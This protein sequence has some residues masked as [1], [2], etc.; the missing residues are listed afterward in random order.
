MNGDGNEHR[1]RWAR[2]RFAVIGPLLARPPGEGRLKEELRRLAEKSWRHPI[3]D[4]PVRFGRSTLERWYY[5]ARAAQSDPIGALLRRTRRDAGAHPSLSE[6]FRQA[7][8]KQYRAHRSW[9]VQLHLDNLAVEVA[10]KPALGPLP[11]YSSVLRYMRA[12][13][14][15]RQRRVHT[16]HTEGAL[17]AMRRREELEIRSFEATHVHA[18]WH[19]DFHHCSRR[20]L[21]ARA[22]SV[23]P[24]LLGILDD[25]S[26]LC[27]HAQWYLEEST[28]TLVHGLIQAIQKRRLPRALMSDNGAPMRGAEFLE[29]LAELGIAHEPTL[30]Y[31]PYQNGKQEVF[32]AQ[33]EGR[34]MAMLETVEELTLE[35]LNEATLAWVEQEYHRTP[36]SELDGQTP[37]ERYLGAPNVGRDSGEGRTLT[38]RFRLRERRRQ[39]K[40]DGTI[41]IEGGRFEIPSA[42]RHLPALTVRY[43]RWDLAV[44]HLYDERHRKT[45]VRIFPLD[46]QK[47]A[48][49][50]RR[51]LDS[52][53]APSNADP[54]PPPGEMAPLLRRLIREYR[55]SGLAP[56]YVPHSHLKT[57]PKS[58]TKIRN[59]KHT[60]EKPS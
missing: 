22:E 9:T 13:G 44:V 23:R 14:L 48:D 3:D 27:C 42:Y 40:S 33:L 52:P 56:A 19:L 20:V 37:L 57:D 26:R 6:A 4:H 30:S 43:A 32:W 35:M 29:G 38:E 51:R 28:E 7:L 60:E 50:R 46:K 54:T 58:I 49:G 12:R 17:E 41:T 34:L 5:H 39:R 55:S 53:Q 8:E 47:N 24:K 16:R 10:D 45:L 36:H 59:D 18:L 11:S 31:S 1:E 25:H 15:D 21:T 2:F